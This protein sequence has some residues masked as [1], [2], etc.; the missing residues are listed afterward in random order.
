LS[1]LAPMAQLGL[2]AQSSDST[3][4]GELRLVATPLG[5]S[6]SLAASKSQ[7][8]STADKLLEGQTDPPPEAPA[9]DLGDA[10]A[11]DTFRS[12]SDQ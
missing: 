8:Q 5:S 3:G 10:P 9:S 7:I 12:P 6:V 1:V 11:S 2:V 4:G